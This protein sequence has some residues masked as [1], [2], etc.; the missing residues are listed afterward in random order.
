MELF[1]KKKEGLS[2]EQKAE[3][4][5]KLGLRVIEMD[6]PKTWKK[7]ALKVYLMAPNFNGEWVREYAKKIGSK[8]DGSF[9]TFVLYKNNT[10]G[11]FVSHD[12]VNEWKYVA[13]KIS[14]VVKM[15]VYIIPD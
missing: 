11:F 5:D 9:L 1:K 14:E 13:D 3:L 4:L 10:L 7:F 2:E 6:P 8:W 12:L 15:P